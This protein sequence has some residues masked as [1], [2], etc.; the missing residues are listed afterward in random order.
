MGNTELQVSVLEHHIGSRDGDE[1]QDMELCDG[2]PCEAQLQHLVFIHQCDVISRARYVARSQLQL[3]EVQLKMQ[4]WK[5][6]IEHHLPIGPIGRTSEHAN[7][8]TRPK[9]SRFY[10]R[11]FPLPLSPFPIP[12]KSLLDQTASIW[13]TRWPSPRSRP[14]IAA[15]SIVAHAS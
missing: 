7:P 5:L 2:Q 10:D 15:S 12:L 3:L 4:T 9:R 6:K 1:K 11:I 8:R 14:A 13:Y